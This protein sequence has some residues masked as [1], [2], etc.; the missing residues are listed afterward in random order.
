MYQNCTR[1]FG[2]R[3]SIV[4]EKKSPNG[5]S[6]Q[7]LHIDYVRQH[8]NCQVLI[9]D[10]CL[11]SHC[12]YTNCN[13]ELYNKELQLLIWCWSGNTSHSQ[14]WIELH[15]FHLHFHPIP[16]RK[17]FHHCYPH[18]CVF[19]KHIVQV[20]EDEFGKLCQ[21]VPLGQHLLH[22][23]CNIDASLQMIWTVHSMLTIVLIT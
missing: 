3:V 16:M 23:D 20:H 2:A 11:R 17:P 7:I 14:L 22:C 6:S 12:E 8:N 1:I 21:D 5:H 9:S 19:L 15:H 18:H 4:F 10:C 13:E